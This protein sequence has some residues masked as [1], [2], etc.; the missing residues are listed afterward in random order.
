MQYVVVDGL[1][2]VSKV[3][4][5]TIR[6]GERG[7]DPAV[8]RAIIRRAIELGIT[9]F[10]TAESSGWGRSERLLG[11]ALDTGDVPGVVVTSKYAPLL[12]LPAV[13]GRRAR[14]SRSRL[15]LPEIPLY[16]LHMPNPL[17]PRRVIMRGFRQA[18]DTGVIGSAG[19]SNHSLRQWQA[20][21][22]ALGHPI[23][24][25]EILL[26][27]LHRGPL[28]DL[29]PWA[30]RHHRLVIAASPLGAGMLTGRYDSGH[31]PADLPWLRRLVM[32]HAALPPTPAN[33][34]RLNPLLEQLRAIAARHGAT[35]A[36]IALA[37][38]IGPDPVVVIPG[39]SSIGQ[40]EANAAAADIILGQDEQQALAAAVGEIRESPGDRPRHS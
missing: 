24:A 8:G 10:D 3:G 28:D 35:P 29:V 36:A 39:A 18:Q 25:N 6:F 16:L 32:R 7:F 21:E 14:A 26:N 5:G 2:P 20:A 15:G 9:H 4:L 22:A 1:P 33:L 23:V 38:T 17:V 30:A 31:P 40:L 11:E 19:V 12:P 13:I 27:L 37:W 34:R